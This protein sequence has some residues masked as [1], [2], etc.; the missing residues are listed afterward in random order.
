MY[1]YSVEVD[2]L[3]GYKYDE[4]KKCYYTDG[5][6]RPDVVADRNNRF[7]VEYFRLEKCAHRWVQLEEQQAVQLELENK[8]IPLNCY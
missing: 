4:T 5:H 8:K 3:L 6:E 7:L 1:F 2:D